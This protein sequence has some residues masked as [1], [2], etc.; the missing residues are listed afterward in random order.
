MSLYQPPIQS[1][2]ACDGNLKT[3]IYILYV[4]IYVY[5]YIYMHICTCIYTYIYSMLSATHAVAKAV[6]DGHLKLI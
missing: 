5:I 1:Q 6:S 4:H 3:N 2:A